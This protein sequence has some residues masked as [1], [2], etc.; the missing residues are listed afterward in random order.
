M[1]QKVHKH[2]NKL[3]SITEETL[4]V[5][6]NV[7]HLSSSLIF[8]RY[9]SLMRSTLLVI[10]VKTIPL[11]DIL[12]FRNYFFLKTSCMITL[13]ELNQRL[14][15]YITQCS[16]TGS[17]DWPFSRYSGQVQKSTIPS[18]DLLQGKKE[19]RSHMGVSLVIEVS[20]GHQI[21]GCQ[22]CC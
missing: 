4:L 17:I 8:E 9:C 15:E 7:F 16:C 3:Y 18:R 11:I 1:V 22:F 19:Q 21:L 20:F 6:V 5:H 14:R 2:S 10:L 12:N 13:T